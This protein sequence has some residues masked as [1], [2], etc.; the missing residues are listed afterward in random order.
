MLTR[1]KVKFLAISNPAEYKSPPLD[2]PTFYHQVS[3][4]SRF[5]FYHLPTNNVF[6]KNKNSHQ[7]E[8]AFVPHNLNYEQLIKLNDYANKRYKIEDFDLVFC[9]TLKPFPPHYLQTLSTWEKRTKFVNIPSNKIEQIE[10]DFLLKVARDYIPETIITEDW[11]EALK[12]LEKH[13]IIVAK[14]VNSCGGRGIFKISY[15]NDLFVIDN[16]LLGKKTFNDFAELIKYSQG[17]TNQPLQLVRYLHKVNQGD[18]RIVVV[19]G[20]IYGA[21]IRRSQTGYWVNNVSADGECFLAD[22]SESE[23][24]AIA[25]TVQHYQKRGLYTLGYDFLLDDEDNWRISE[26]NV[27][28]IGGFA[29]L[30]QLTGKPVMKKFLDWLIKFA[31]FNPSL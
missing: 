9:R 3:N 31:Q 12:F 8:V 1:K 19:D 13:Q 18:K 4:D 6:Q 16:F 5:D 20:E 30:E 24:K 15:E 26:I 7:I 10:A 25:N 28:N 21:Y 27:G 22:I 14:Q 17:T 11:Q 29:R 2:V 23:K